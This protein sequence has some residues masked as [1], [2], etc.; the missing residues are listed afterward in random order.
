MKALLK[1]LDRDWAKRFLR[2]SAVM[3]AGTMTANVFNYLYHTLMGRMLGPADYGVIASLT[4]LSFF[5]LAPVG[6]IGYT[7]MKYTAGYA[8]GGET[9][10]IRYLLSRMTSFLLKA[11]L[12]AGLAL[13]AVSP[14]VAKFLNFKNP[15]PLL[16][17]APLMLIAYLV[18][19]NKGVI[20]G[21]QR[22][23]SLSGITG[24]EAISKVV[25][26]VALVWAGFA[27]NGAV[28]ASVLSVGIVYAVTFLPLRD[29]RRAEP[30]K[31]DA[32]R[33]VA[34]YSGPVF[35]I[36]L[37]LNG[38]SSLDII[39]AKHFLTPL[40][41]GHYAGLALLGKIVVFSGLTV[42]GVM[43]PEVAGRHTANRRHRHILALT[44]AVVSA[45][46]GFVVVLYLTVPK[47]VIGILF[48][49]KY[50]SAAP[51]AGLFGFAM[52]CLTLAYVISNYCMAIGKTSFVWIAVAAAAAEFGALWRW[53]SS[54][55]Q[56]VTVMAIVMG[57]FLAGMAAYIGLLSIY[58]RSKKRPS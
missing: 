14:F 52:L 56:I 32:L 15:L 42:V 3:A 51:Y 17:L 58:E 57:L 28:T 11:G 44:L 35:I 45:L 25:L 1:G 29:I 7:A 26:A 18:P 16:I 55:G 37:C 2:G 46:S 24:L 12:A 33:A 30:V 20:Q 48:G 53:H 19:I 10:K 6:T 21:L 5:I 9:G 22:F 43:F 41:A 38:Y 50:L 8:A 49:S 54:M 40:A 4:S 36:S 23:G 27:V 39:A 31:D 13:A 34:K 47:L